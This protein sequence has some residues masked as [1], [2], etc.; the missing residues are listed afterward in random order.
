M[1]RQYPHTLY[2]ESLSANSTRDGD[3]NWNSQSA[4][5]EELSSCREESDGRG[6]EVQGADGKFHRYSSIIYLPK[7]C[8]DIEFGRKVFVKDTMSSTIYR[9]TGSVIKFERNQLNCR[10]WI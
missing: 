4:L 2:G 9:A 8:P 1:V 6:R 5:T 10:I 3:G 7:S